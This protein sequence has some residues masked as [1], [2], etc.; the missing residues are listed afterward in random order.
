MLLVALDC[1][2][3]Q[4]AMSVT[5]GADLPWI[6]YQAEDGQTNAQVLGPSRQKWDANHIEAEA[7]GRK[8]VRLDKTGDYVSFTTKDAANAI[9]V[10]YSIP[11]APSGGGIDAT[12]GLYVNGTRVRTLSLTSRYS[13]SYL[14]GKIGDPMADIPGP[15]PHTFFDEIR[16][17]IDPIPQ[18]ATVMLRRDAEDTAPFYVIDLVDLEQAPP[19]LTMPEG[20]TSVT[21]F[22]IFPDD[23]VDHGDDIVRAMRSTSKLWFPPGNYLADVLHGGNMGLDNPGIEVRGA[24]MWYTNIRGAK[25]MFFCYG[26]TSR[27]VFGDFSIF[28]ET[29]VRDEERTGPQKAFSGPMGKNSLIENVWIEHKVAAIWVGNDPPYQTQPTDG[30]IIRN[31]RIRNTYA[32]GVN[33]DNGTSNSIVEN[34]H[35]RNTGDDAVAI[36][37]I[38][39]TKWVA[40]KTYEF[41]ENYFSPEQRNASDQG[42]SHGNIVRH[43]SVQMPWRASCF[44]VYGGGDNMFRD[45]TCED[46]LTYPGIMVNHEFS[47][48]AFAQ[49]STTFQNILLSRAGGTMFGEDTPNPLRH[50]AL[51][52][53]LREGSISDIYMKDVDIVEPAYAGIEFRGFGTPYAQGARIPPYVL[54]AADAATMNNVKL[55]NVNIMRSGTYGIEVADGGGR[56]SVR[57]SGVTVVDSGIAPL[58]RENALDTFFVKGEGNKGW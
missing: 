43:V 8:A 13:W 29:K 33:L 56:G 21:Q 55:E 47:P 45:S 11:D 38:Q 20:F 17:L 57:F 23:G 3:A 19:P 9:V 10:R 32:D 7:I 16:L 37:S 34:C 48:Y 39:W 49:P 42:I 15:Q 53:Y 40:Y 18:G 52:F 1:A 2:G 54:Q 46:V 30:L 6:E 26:A 22:G 25:S 35:I 4:Q 5:R 28:G 51:K 12:L 24:G 58:Q 50:G 14:G 41:G 27:C 31:C 44:A 36:W